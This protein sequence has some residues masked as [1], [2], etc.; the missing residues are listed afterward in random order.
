MEIPV[1]EDAIIYTEQVDMRLDVFQGDDS[2]LL[3]H[4]AEVSGQSQLALLA[5]A[6][7]G[8]NEEDF[9]AYGC[10]CQTGYY[11]CIAVALIDVSIERCRAKNIF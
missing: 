3:H 5:F 9:S 10:P 6:Q 11:S 7:G 4:V 2:R 1:F 8:F